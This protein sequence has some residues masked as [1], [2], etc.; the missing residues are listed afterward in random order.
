MR[1]CHWNL[2]PVGGFKCIEA[3]HRAVER[4]NRVRLGTDKLPITEPEWTANK[5]EGVAELRR[6]FKQYRR[7][8]NQSRVAPTYQEACDWFRKTVHKS[9]SFP[10]LSMNVDSLF[11]YL[12][13]AAIEDPT[14]KGRFTLGTL[15]AADLFHAWAITFRQSISNLQ[16]V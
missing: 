13:D 9:D 10:F 2:D 4:G 7:V 8:F 5:R 3:L 11:G 15:K 1:I 12:D 14:I 6:A 16:K